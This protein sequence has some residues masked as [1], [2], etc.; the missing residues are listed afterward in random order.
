MDC[1]HLL[2][3]LSAYLDGELTEDETQEVDEHLEGCEA[4]RQEL[5]RLER[6]VL[7]V[8]RLPKE[9]A[10][11]ALASAVAERIRAVPV[12]APPQRRALWSVPTT[13]AAA[14]VLLLACVIMLKVRPGTVGR[15][16]DRATEALVAQA[17]KQEALAQEVVTPLAVSTAKMKPRGGRA[18]DALGVGGRP[19][20]AVATPKPVDKA[21]SKL[22]KKAE[23]QP[24]GIVAAGAK[25]ATAAR[26]TI[27]EEVGVDARRRRERRQSETLAA[28]ETYEAKDVRD[29]RLLRR[30]APSLAEIVKRKAGEAEQL[31]KGTYVADADVPGLRRTGEQPE[32]STPA[33][34]APAPETP[35][36]RPARAVAKRAEAAVGK[37]PAAEPSAP[38]PA[39]ETV[40][41]VALAFKKPVEPVAAAKAELLSQQRE[42]A[43][44]RR[45]TLRAKDVNRAKDAVDRLLASMSLERDRAESGVKLDT[46]DTMVVGLPRQDCDRLIVRLRGMKDVTVAEVARPAR[47]RTAVDERSVAYAGQAARGTGS[48]ATRGLR[49]SKEARRAPVATRQVVLRIVFEEIPRGK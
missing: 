22:G 4:C 36:G 10:P 3:Q 8:R 30:P 33:E 17:P 2:E 37:A 42:H 23:A 1:E 40:V 38:R 49:E 39:A 15:S 44:E 25:A 34:T 16:D 35:D 9:K 19:R 18:S 7:M 31:P 12:P 27:S 13:L 28:G 5:S 48:P 45:L 26:S 6:T 21:V 11:S 29:R 41:D 46:I 24:P 32:T 43:P 47:T 14:A 20:Y